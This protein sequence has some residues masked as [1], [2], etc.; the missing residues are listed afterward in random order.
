MK[1]VILSFLLILSSCAS[2]DQKSKTVKIVNQQQAPLLSACT[3]KEPVFGSTEFGQ[4]QLIINLKNETAKKNGNVLLSTM[5]TERGFGWLNLSEKTS[6]IVYE[7]PEVTLD[8]LA[9]FGHW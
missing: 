6:G 5:I 1:S 2:L 9:D 3:V 8:R 7:C 4:E